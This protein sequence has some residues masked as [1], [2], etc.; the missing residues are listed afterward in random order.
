LTL[1]P[2][3]SRNLCV[4]LH[5]SRQPT[6]VA[7]TSGRSGR[8]RTRCCVTGHEDRR[9]DS[10]RHGSSRGLRGSRAV[11][12]ESSHREAAVRTQAAVVRTL[13]DELHRETPGADVAKDLR[14]Q[15]VEESARLVTAIEEVSRMRLQAPKEARG[16]RPRESREGQS[17]WPRILVVEDHD[18]TR[19]AI[20]QG[21]A[22]EYEIVTACNGL[23][24]LK[25]ATQG[26]F[27]AIVTDIWMPEMD[28]VTMVE[29]I[30]EALAPAQVPVIFLTGDAKPQNVAA[31][32]SAGGTSYM[33]KPIDLDLLDREVRGLVATKPR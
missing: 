26:S 11:K 5:V 20:A 18:G 29:R 9:D 25:A 4:S 14:A 3:A 27:D 31:G 33:V 10:S 24:G 30:R 17:R 16:P 15:A 19:R 32:F 21:L 2:R 22:P 8:W 6:I 1:S 28:G 13:A 12:D 23:E 7:A